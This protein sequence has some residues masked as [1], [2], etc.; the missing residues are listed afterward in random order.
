MQDGTIRDETGT[1]RLLGY[2][3]DVGRGDGRA[4][5][6][7]EIGPQHL[8]RQGILHGGIAASVLD[9]AMGTTASL[10]VDASGRQ[11]FTTLSLTVS[12]LAPGRPGGAVAEGRITGGGRKTLFIEG[13]LTHEDGTIIARAQ[14]VF[15]QSATGPGSVGA[16]GQSS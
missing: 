7:I 11:P 13:V 10:S 15:K 1:Q 8:N 4:R 5:C 9:S 6:G 2:M 16:P 3:L 12:F 14:G